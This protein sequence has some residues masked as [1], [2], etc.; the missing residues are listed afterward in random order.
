[1]GKKGGGCA[2]CTHHLVG[3]CE[4]EETDRVA[5]ILLDETDRLRWGG[6]W[7]CAIIDGLAVG[8]LAVGGLAIGVW[9]LGFV[10]VGVCG[11]WGLAIGVAV[12]CSHA[13]YVGSPPPVA[14]IFRKSVP[15]L[16]HARLTPLRKSA[17]APRW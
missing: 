11:D 10:A 13:Q 17:D 16:A 5:T 12:A 6:S 15:Q 4:H 7:G 9:L 2:W 1:M 3:L 8:G 14:S